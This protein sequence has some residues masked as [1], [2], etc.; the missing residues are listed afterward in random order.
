[1]HHFIPCRL[2]LVHLT[3]SGPFPLKTGRMRVSAAE[4]V[5]MILVRIGSFVGG[6]LRSFVN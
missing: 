5:R 4:R 1:M 3:Y 2:Q 6:P